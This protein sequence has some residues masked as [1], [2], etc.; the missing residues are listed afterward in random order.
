MEDL[1]DKLDKIASLVEGIP[2]KNED[3]VLRILDELIGDMEAL[4]LIRYK[5]KMPPTL[6]HLSNWRIGAT[7]E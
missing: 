3:E 2:Y 4:M 1:Q 7:S 6:K 5:N